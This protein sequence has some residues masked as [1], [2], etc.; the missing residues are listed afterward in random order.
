MRKKKQLALIE[1]CKILSE[2]RSV[3]AG[4]SMPFTMS[5]ALETGE[6]VYSNKGA[7]FGFRDLIFQYSAR[8]KE[9]GA[10]KEK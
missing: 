10:T 8:E 9:S 4:T 7:R 6:V 2:K 1:S 5:F 3:F